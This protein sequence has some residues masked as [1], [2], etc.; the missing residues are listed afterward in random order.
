MQI[1]LLGGTGPEGKG[2]AL[3]FAAAGAQVVIGSRL[4]ERAGAA[5][6]E[7]NARL[8]KPLIR[9]ATNEEMLAES[10]IVFLAVPFGQAVAALVAYRDCF[11]S[12][13]I[14][15]DVT[16]PMRFTD[17]LPAYAQPEAGSGAE[18]VARHVPPG[19][20]VVAAFKEIPAHAL[21]EVETPLDCDALVCG[22]SREARD[23]VMAAAG[24]IPSLRPL[25]AGPLKMASVIERMTV[26]AVYL[27]RRYRRRGARF[28]VQG[29]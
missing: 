18:L 29:I 13:T 3:R 26:L 20:S 17:G 28:R 4:G 2:L 8:A 7:C 27:N 14:L 21:A 10:E 9:G 15:V 19:V 11:R 5:A 24:L 25:D 12:G 16:V 23:A 22:D 6:G 1:G